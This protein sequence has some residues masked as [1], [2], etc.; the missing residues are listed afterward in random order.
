LLVQPRGVVVSANGE[1]AFAH[2]WP[3]D[4]V[5]SAKTGGG[6][7]DTGYE[8]KWLVGHVERG[9]R[10]WVFVSCTTGMKQSPLAAVELA[11]RSL[12]EEKVL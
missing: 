2:P 8:V 9:S 12:R 5:V 1:H 6:S 3:P 11:A 4:A 10:A 7:Y